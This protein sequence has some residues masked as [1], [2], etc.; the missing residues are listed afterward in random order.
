MAE[1]NEG[2]APASPKAAATPP[3]TGALAQREE[4]PA[5]PQAAGT[6]DIATWVGAGAIAAMLLVFVY[7]FLKKRRQR[8]AELE[9]PGVAERRELEEKRRVEELPA[10]PAKPEEAAP[11]RR[12]VEEA[13]PLT[14]AEL[15]AMEAAEQARKAVAE[16]EA[17]RLEAKRLLEEAREARDA[18]AQ[19][20]AEEAREAARRA[21]EEAE[22]LQ[23]KAEE[24]E[25]RLKQEEEERKKAEYREKRARE[26]AERERRKAEA[27]EAQR[28]AEEEKR[29]KALEEEAA[30]RRA[31]EEERRKVEAEAGKTL[32]E[33]LSKTRGGFIAGLNA[34]FGRNKVLDESILGELEDVL[35]SADIGVKTATNLLEFAREKVKAKDL[36]DPE[37]LKDAIREE[38]RKIVSIKDGAADLSAHK[39]YVIM[40]VGVNGSGKTTTIGKLAAKLTAQGKK[41]LLGAGDTFRAAAAEQLE[42]WGKRAGAEVVRG[43]EGSD[44][45]AVIFDALKKGQA[46]GYDVVIADTAGR[47][48]TKAP[49]MDE[50]RRVRRVMDKALPGAPHEILLVLDS[51]NGQN[52]I[53]Q[54]REFHAALQVTG[55][56]LTKLDGTAKGG[57]VIGICDELKVPVRYV[58]IGESVGDLRPF[59]PKEYVEALFD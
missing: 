1:V 44:P 30:R 55:L 57:V 32:A 59:D 43:K 2:L 36:A 45:G 6:P 21:R 18:E 51:T 22:A 52:A 7:A 37:K 27:E 24:E 49:L 8:R 5:G 42:V 11:A 3:V 25:R 39:P 20:R 16:A 58:G 13:R 9:E 35:F 41:V 40:V 47:L 29:L 54:A 48:H 38:I 17:A 10:P 33:G 31:E 4:Q 23:A 53:A 46:E 15:A 34:F 12:K 14:E 26:A 19:R 50:L 56:V 28:R